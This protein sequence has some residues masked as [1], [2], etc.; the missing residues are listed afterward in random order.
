MCPSMSNAVHRRRPVAIVPNVIAATMALL[1]AA[2]AAA[3]LPGL[4]V[5]Q[6]G[7]VRPGWAVAANGGSSDAVSAAAIAAAWTPSSA[8]YQ[9]NVGAGILEPDGDVESGTSGG[10]RLAVPIGTPWTGRPTSAFGLAAFVGTGYSRF[11]EAG[12]LRLPIG[13]GLG[14]RRRLG[15][16]R[17]ISAFVTPFYSWVRRTGELPEG[18]PDERQ[19]S[20]LVRASVGAEALVTA[21]LGVTIGYEFG[22]TAGEGRP[23]PTGGILGGGLSYI[24]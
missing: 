7:F 21:R 17:A 5:L 20:N 22:A 8:R 6:N 14:Y 19:D 15:E 12:E 11:E 2:P 24:F 16:T 23:G 13:V 9:V 18:V 3:Q 1:L 4:P 10:V